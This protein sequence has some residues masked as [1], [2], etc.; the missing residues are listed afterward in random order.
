MEVT[1][2]TREPIEAF[3]FS[4]FAI[5]CPM[6]VATRLARVHITGVTFETY[7]TQGERKEIE[8]ALV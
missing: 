3:T 6:F 4:S 5:A 7:T 2:F 1:V 8:G